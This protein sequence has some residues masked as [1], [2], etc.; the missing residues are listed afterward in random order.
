MKVKQL[1]E[2]LFGLNPDAEC[3]IAQY[4]IQTGETVLQYMQRCCNTE[5]QDKL[6]QVW[7]GGELVA[8][9]LMKQSSHCN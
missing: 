5:H 1:Q 4:S 3:V 8:I 6:N 9:E 7:F 2:A